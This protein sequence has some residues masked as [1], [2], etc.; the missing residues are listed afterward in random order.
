MAWGS[1]QSN[2]LV[3]LPEESKD[4]ICEL[5]RARGSA[6]LGHPRKIWDIFAVEL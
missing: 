1:L 6:F 2:S 5:V 4:L 3:Q